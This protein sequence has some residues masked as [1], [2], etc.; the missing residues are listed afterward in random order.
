[1]RVCIVTTEFLGVGP[2]GGLGVS[3]RTLGRHLVAR[4]IEVSVVAPGGGQQGEPSPLMLEGIEVRTYDRRNQRAFMRAVRAADADVYQYTQASLGA[5]L[6]QWAMPDRAHVVECADPRDWSDWLIDFRLPTHSALRLIPSFA[7]FGTRP[8]ALSARQADAVQVPA[9]FLQEKVRR[10][11]RLSADPRYVPMPFDPPVA[12][13]KSALPLVVFV[14]RLVR[15]KRPEVFLDVAQRF[16]AVRFVV[17]GG[18]SDQSYASEMK[19]R[20]AA[21][22]NVEF[23]DFIDQAS[24]L[25]FF[26]YLSEAWIL[27]NTAARE[28]LPLTFIEAAANGCAILSACD[29]DGYA[30][31]FGYHVTDGDF[32][33]GLDALMAG[34]AWRMAGE[35][36]RAHVDREHASD[37]AIRHQLSLYE[38]ALA[39]SA[40]RSGRGRLKTAPVAGQ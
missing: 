36:A 2:C 7:Y 30:S 40:E 27:I 16:P 19:R 17:M 34:D 39:R 20:G 29:P 37:A 28:G 8:A 35:R 38:T 3:A 21:L 25:R 15:R 9:R 11:Y 5:Y 24:D 26:G 18:G 22:S 4:G 14:G 31:N 10:L 6:A 13:K 32:A 23:T 33:R 1:M 12:V